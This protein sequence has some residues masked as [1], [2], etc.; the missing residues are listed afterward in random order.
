M[1]IKNRIRLIKET[2]PKNI[3]IVAATKKQEISKINQAIDSRIKIIGENYVQ[4]AGGK[5]LKL[6]E[7]I[8]FHLIGHL[9]KNKVKKAV[10]I[11][12][13]IQTIDSKKIADDINK[14][15]KKE[16]K[17]MSVLIEVNIAKE[18]TKK[19]CLPD[20]VIDLAD[21]ILKLPSL[22]LKGL[23]TMAPYFSNPEK[24]RPYFKKA[25]KIFDKLRLK[26]PSIDTLSMG[27]SDSYKVAIEEGA[28]MIRLG[29]AIFGSRN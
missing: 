13:M 5:Y 19:G 16:N 8:R 12:D 11:F 24:S 20:K 18:K 21:Y 17:I 7:K 27:M 28:T 15:C 25:R 14:E 23:M 6:K 1:S 22:E 26:N 10:K 3:T 2:I 9:Q 29:T 4:E